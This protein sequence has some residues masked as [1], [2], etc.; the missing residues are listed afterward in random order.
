M[1][2]FLISKADN[3]LYNIC[4]PFSNHPAKRLL[5]TYKSDLKKEANC[6][7]ELNKI[8]NVLNNTFLVLANAKANIY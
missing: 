4:F 6:Y 1:R 5:N 7:E 2:D 8:N 3:N